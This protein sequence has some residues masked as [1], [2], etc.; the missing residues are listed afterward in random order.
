[1]DRKNLEEK[2]KSSNAELKEL[3]SALYCQMGAMMRSYNG[4]R[5][6]FGTPPKQHDR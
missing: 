3:I 6:I 4:E 2:I 5:G 1:M